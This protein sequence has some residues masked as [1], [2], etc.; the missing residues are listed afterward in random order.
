MGHDLDQPLTE[1]EALALIRE[2]EGQ[3]V[4]FKERPGQLRVAIKTLAAFAS[5]AEGGY[6]FIGIR[7]DGELTR[8]QRANNAEEQWANEIKA[9][10][11]SMTTGEPLLPDIYSF[12]Q[13]GFS[14]IE[15]RPS[16]GDT[17][18]IAYGRRFERV[19]KSTHEVKIGFRQLARAFQLHLIDEESNEPLPFRFC[20]KCGSENLARWSAIDYQHDEAFHFIEC[21]DCSWSEWTQ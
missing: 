18:Y 16:Q 2:G 4:E 6:L 3:T 11:I 14:V 8:F 13:P 10:A 12:G 5:Q 1:G 17:P 7:D 20:E 9:N 15:V 19:G 21:Q